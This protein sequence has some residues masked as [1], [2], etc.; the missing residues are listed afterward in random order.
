MDP[1][2]DILT[3]A[4]VR[5]TL[6][7]RIDAGSDW[8][9]WAEQASD[10]AFHAVTAGTAWV[11]VA[12]AEPVELMPG[13][14]VLLPHGTAHVLGSD[15]AAVERTTATRFDG[16]EQT[17]PG[18]IRIGTGETRTQILCAHYTH[19]PAV[20]TDVLG[21]LPDVVLIRAASAPS[22]S[23]AI[24]L[25][26]LELTD[27]QL[28]SEVVVNR[29]VDVL[30]VQILRAWVAAQPE[31]ALPSWLSGL[32]DPVVRAA[33]SEIH[34]DPAQ[35]WTTATLASAVAVSRATLARRFAAAVGESPGAYLT[36]W[37]MDL[38]AQ[39]LRDTDDPIDAIASGVGYTSVYAFSRAFRRSRS[40][41]PGRFRALARA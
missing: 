40:V 4:G 6:G 7:A 8:G 24:R 37:R 23:S 30:L 21:L 13:D 39:R 16:A 34:A 2:T 41:P 26:A 12:G 31:A 5:S 20:E 9:W 15:R 33:V 19:D 32:R 36:R 3:R 14:V 11:S 10:A 1:L 17:G 18:A 29:L 38:A 27:P 28:A 35:P 22:L 25:I